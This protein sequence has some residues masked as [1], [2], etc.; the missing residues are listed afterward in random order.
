MGG[1]EAP[2]LAYHCPKL[3]SR[4]LRSPCG[5]NVA[6]AQELRGKFPQALLGP[7]EHCITCQGQDLIVSEFTKAKMSPVVVSLAEGE[8]IIGPERMKKLMAG[9]EADAGPA[10]CKH[11]PEVP[12]KLTKN[13][14]SMGRCVACLAATVA[15]NSRNRGEKIAKD[16]MT[17][18]VARDLAAKP[19]PGVRQNEAAAAGNT[20]E[21][22]Y[23]PMVASRQAVPDFQ[24][25]PCPGFPE[26][27]TI[28]DPIPPVCTHPPDRPARIDSLGRN[29]RLCTKCLAT[30][31]RMVIKANR[32]EGKTGP[33]FYL[34]LN[35]GKY[36]GLKDRLEDSAEENERSLVQEIMYWLKLAMREQ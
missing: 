24:D 34:P 25:T 35:Q 19:E 12:A 29:M 6:K 28:P 26:A 31:G 7:I 4:H 27:S 20:L 21:P 15:R 22:S 18:A 13:G 10:F 33:P 30:R 2:F 17:K 16:T 1:V 23:S 32:D 8:K 36:A 14:R 5:A 11:H 3:R 9:T